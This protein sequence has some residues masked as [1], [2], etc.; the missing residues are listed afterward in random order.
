MS[1][2]F[3]LYNVSS[4][5][6]FDLT[7]YVV[8]ST[9][10]PINGIISTNGNYNYA[11]IQYSSILGLDLS[12]YNNTIKVTTD[13]TITTDITSYIFGSG[14]W[15][16]QGYV[17]STEL[18]SGENIITNYGGAGG[19]GPT[20]YSN[21]LSP[22]G[23]AC[24]FNMYS[25]ASNDNNI[26][27]SNINFNNSNDT[28]AI[29]SGRI[30]TG[31]CNGGDAGTVLINGETASY[32]GPPGAGGFAKS[33]NSNGTLIISDEPFVQINGWY[34]NNSS[35]GNFKFPTNKSDAFYSSFTFV[36]GT[37][38][39]NHCIYSGYG[40]NCTSSNYMVPCNGGAGSGAQALFMYEAI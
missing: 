35:V 26:S 14:G 12:S 33:Y 1:L 3:E 18:A 19:A 29:C 31:I 25:N 21:T 36:D 24:I 8:Y 9:I 22:N 40:G 39:N 7:P 32:T 28:G 16:V 27:E 11:Y 17:S 6:T 34:L 37:N 13:G 23:Y 38:T 4:Q 2:K 5:A 10:N 20:F 15:G 30:G